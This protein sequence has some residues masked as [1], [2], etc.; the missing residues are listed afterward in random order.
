MQRATR[1]AADV[2]RNLNVDH[3]PADELRKLRALGDNEQFHYIRNPESVVM[4]TTGSWGAVGGY[5]AVCPGWGHFGGLTQSRR[6]Q[7]P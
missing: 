6:V 5:T 1:N 3:M 4:L 7:F 2:R